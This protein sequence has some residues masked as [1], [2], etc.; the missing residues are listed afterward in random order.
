CRS[1]PE[2]RTRTRD[3]PRA[4]RE[5]RSHRPRDRAL[6]RRLRGR[7][8]RHARRRPPCGAVAAVD[9][10]RRR[11]CVDARAERTL[12]RGAPVLA[13]RAAARDT[14]RAEVL[15]PRHDRALPGHA[16]RAHV[17]R[18]RA[19]AQPALLRSL[20]V[21]REEVPPMKRLLVVLAA[22]SALAA[23]AA[24]SAHPL[25]NFTVNHFARVQ[26][27]GNRLYVRYVVDLA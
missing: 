25:G 14:G 18:A 3:R 5:R 15:P 1:A 20:V 23:P 22:A 7:A 27:S 9:R 13:A 12:R 21:D 19:G 4:A 6:P 11:A 16:V 17:V 24:A 2:L 26:V 8:S 10:R